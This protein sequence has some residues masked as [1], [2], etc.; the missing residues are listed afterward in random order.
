MPNVIDKDHPTETLISSLRC[1]VF[2]V[3]PYDVLVHLSLASQN[4]PSSRGYTGGFG[5]PLMQKD[6]G[7]ATD[8]GAACSV[9]TMLVCC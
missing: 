5:V 4:V 8:A 3:C 6:L 7:L 9:C 1:L 2:L